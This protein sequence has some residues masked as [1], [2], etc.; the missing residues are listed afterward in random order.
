MQACLFGSLFAEI[1]KEES[2]PGIIF[3]GA[4]PLVPPAVPKASAKRQSILSTVFHVHETVIR[5]GR[6]RCAAVCAG[7]AAFRAF[8]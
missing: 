2:H 4:I 6:C 8:P 1:K 3:P 5:A 7:I